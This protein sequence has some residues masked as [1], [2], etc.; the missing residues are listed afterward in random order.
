M[1]TLDKKLNIGVPC[2]KEISVPLYDLTL[3]G[4]KRRVDSISEERKVRKRLSRE[5]EA[6][7]STK[8]L[9]KNKEYL[10]VIN[11]L[12][13][14]ES[15]S[16]FTL[17]SKQEIVNL[18]GGLASANRDSDIKTINELIDER[19]AHLIEIRGYRGGLST[20]SP[21]YEEL[22]KNYSF[23]LGGKPFNITLEYYLDNQIN[24]Y[25]E[26]KSFLEQN[27]DKINYREL[28][29]EY[30]CSLD[31]NKVALFLAREYLK[32]IVRD[33]KNNDY[34]FAQHYMF[35]L[36]SFF[37]DM[38]NR[39]TFISYGKK[40]YSYESLLAVYKRILKE[41]PSL[42]ELDLDR[43]L[44]ISSDYKTNR[45]LIDTFIKMKEISIS[46]SFVKEGTVAAAKTSSSTKKVRTVSEKEKQAKEEEKEKVKYYLDLRLYEYL[47]R[48]PLARLS[49]ENY[50]NNY[51]AFVYENGLV[52]ADRL[53]NVNTASQVNSDAAYLF[54]IDNFDE[55]IKLSKQELISNT[56][57]IIH[58]DG[59]ESKLDARINKDLGIE[60]ERVLEYVKRSNN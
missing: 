47:R 24:Y 23:L 21:A 51:V 52:P 25:L 20:M 32:N 35:Y 37:N 44:F 39:K 22:V 16:Y 29:N 55:K 13:D 4:S 58:R 6:E 31:E 28:L 7:L 34:T 36:T 41:Y 18:F 19:I 8:S 53:K 12:S 11:F 45:E 10:D 50:F 3:E 38:S 43:S 17:G 14:Q 42:K 2:Y 15:L 5:I 40:K 46:E 54:N 30:E 1:S 60:K 27:K 48:N 56:E 33:L 49:C 9:S 57:R 26:L 59:W